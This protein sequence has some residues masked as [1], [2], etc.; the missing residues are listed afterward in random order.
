MPEP[1]PEP[2]RNEGLH[3]MEFGIRIEERFFERNLHLRSLCFE[4]NKTREQ[5]LAAIENDDYF[6]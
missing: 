5:V 6:K 4:F 3:G 1:K 2:Y